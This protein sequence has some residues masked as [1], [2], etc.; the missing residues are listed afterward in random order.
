LGFVRD[1]FHNLR[2]RP[3]LV[4][5]GFLSIF[6]TQL[7]VNIFIFGYLEMEKMG[8]FS[9]QSFTI[10]AY[11]QSE[12]TDEK[13][14][15]TV[16]KLKNLPDVS[17]I[18]FLSKEDAQ[19]K[20]L[21][22]FELT[23]EDFPVDENPFPLS[24]EIIPKRVESIPEL[25]N[26]VKNTGLFDDVIYG[27]KN[28]DVFVK[29]YHMLLSVGSIVLFL[30]FIFSLIVIIN[31]IRISI[32]SRKEEIRVFHLIGATE[33]FIRRPI[34][35]EGF[36][37]GLF[38]GISAFLL[39]ILVFHFLLDFLHAAFPFFPWI[40]LTDIMAPLLVVDTFMGGVIGI[41]GSLIACNSVL[42]EVLR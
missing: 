8:K 16:Q 11:F 17:S 7:I 4:L 42:K 33:T 38:A 40:N 1:A 23:P 5:I 14:Q 31:L 28:V 26:Q 29:F 6:F 39:S 20:F 34:I 35:T 2:K 27:G 24:V 41:L 15:E 21:E 32:Q 25:A 37:E 12:V 9:G 36:F 10:K 18:V 22:Y 13:A 30:V 19:K 3:S